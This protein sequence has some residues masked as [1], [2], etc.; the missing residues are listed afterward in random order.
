MLVVAPN[1][2]A[3]QDPHFIAANKLVEER[4]HTLLKGIHS[5]ILGLPDSQSFSIERVTSI[6]LIRTGGKHG[7]KLAVGRSYIQI[8]VEIGDIVQVNCRHGSEEHCIVNTL[9]TNIK[10]ARDHSFHMYLIA[11]F[12]RVIG[13]SLWAT[14]VRVESQLNK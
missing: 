1:V 12:F 11:S 9:K 14:G 13:E 6:Q 4:G 7:G 2:S 8:K 3:L 10:D 5:S